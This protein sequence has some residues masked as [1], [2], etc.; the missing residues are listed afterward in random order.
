MKNRY[1]SFRAIAVVVLAAGGFSSVVAAPI[2]LNN[3]FEANT[4]LN[5]GSNYDVGLSIASVTD[6][7]FATSG[8][9]TYDGLVTAGTTAGFTGGL[10]ALSPFPDGTQA[11][12][13]YGPSATFSQSI[14]GFDA[15]DYTVSFYANGRT[16][17]GDGV[18]PFGVTLG[19]T[20]L[21]FSASATITPNASWVL[22][23]S[24][25]VTMAAGTHTLAFTSAGTGDR[26]S[27]IDVVN[28]NAV[29]EP[30]AMALLGIGG[31]SLIL[32]RRSREGRSFLPAKSPA[33]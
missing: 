31:L 20:A 18:L 9:A 29:P 5:P 2:V 12:F 16:A 13:I 3:S 21:T 32:R 25:A 8:G 28:V 7:T 24:D 11:A 22:Y 6:W 17:A 23:T 30:T 4:G 26:A 1:A 14:S 27:F 19:G 33:L 10:N 15:G